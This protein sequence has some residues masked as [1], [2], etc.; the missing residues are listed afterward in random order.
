MPDQ[1]FRFNSDVD[2]FPIQTYIWETEHPKAVIVISHGAAEHALRY[3]RFARAL[4]AAGM[5]VYAAD[6]RGHGRSPGPEGLGDFG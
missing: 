1:E 6:H 2:G 4:N 3:D 5:N